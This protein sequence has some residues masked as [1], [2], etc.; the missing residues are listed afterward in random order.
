M[1]VLGEGDDIDSLLL[2]PRPACVL[3]LSQNGTTLRAWNAM[4]GTLL[5][6]RLTSQSSAEAKAVI[7]VLPDVTGDGSSD[8]FFAQGQKAQVC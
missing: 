5:W 1:Q 4:D 2:V 8:L 6:Q 3:S 7:S